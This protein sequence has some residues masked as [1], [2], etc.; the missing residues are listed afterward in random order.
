MESGKVKLSPDVHEAL[1]GKLWRE[2]FGREV[3]ELRSRKPKKNGGLVGSELEIV[4]V[5][6]WNTGAL[7]DLDRSIA[8]MLDNLHRS[9]AVPAFVLDRKAVSDAQKGSE[10]V[11]GYGTSGQFVRGYKHSMEGKPLTKDVLKTEEA[12]LRKRFFELLAH[13]M[14]QTLTELL[15]MERDSLA[16]LA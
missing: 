14:L 9:Y 6:L 5:F 3:F 12:V 13:P 15:S 7:T 11:V 10:F 16:P 4:R 8:R 2:A 1:K